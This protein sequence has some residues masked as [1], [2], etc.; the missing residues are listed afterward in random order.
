MSPPGNFTGYITHQH[1]VDVNRMTGIPLR[2]FTD[3]QRWREPDTHYEAVDQGV[4]SIH[5]VHYDRKSLNWSECLRIGLALVAGQYW[6]EEKHP[7]PV[8]LFG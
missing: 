4:V 7:P 3:R 1:A 8:E 5:D 6:L 2:L